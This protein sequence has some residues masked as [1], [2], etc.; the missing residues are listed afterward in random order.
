MKTIKNS[1]KCTHDSW[2]I[3]A[4]SVHAT[5]HSQDGDTK[6]E[7]TMRCQKCHTMATAVRTEY[8]NESSCNTTS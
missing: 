6:M 8:H 3:V 7:C 1:I 2:E 4:G 5:H